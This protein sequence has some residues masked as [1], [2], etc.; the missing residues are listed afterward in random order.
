MQL[1]SSIRTLNEDIFPKLYGLN[2][3]GY[4][5]LSPRERLPKSAPRIDPRDYLRDSL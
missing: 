1:R 3:I 4:R 5:P 2:T